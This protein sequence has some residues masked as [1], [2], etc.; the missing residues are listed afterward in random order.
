MPSV[1]DVELEKPA[2]E[3]KVERQTCMV[4]TSPESPVEITTTDAIVPALKTDLE[5]LVKDGS[6]DKVTAWTRPVTIEK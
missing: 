2:E 4:A 1:V 5:A 3:L 6:S